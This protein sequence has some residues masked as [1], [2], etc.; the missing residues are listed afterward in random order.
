M[1]VIAWNCRSGT[2]EQRLKQV[3]R[4]TPDVLFLQECGADANCCRQVRGRKNIALMAPTGTLSTIAVPPTAGRGSIAARIAPSGSRP[5]VALGIWAQSPNYSADVI[6]TL[7]SYRLP[8]KSTI[9]LGDFNSG[10]RLPSGKVSTSHAAMLAAFERKGL[11]SA[12]HAF[13]DVDHGE[14]DDPTYFHLGK[15]ASPWHIDFCFVPR[16]WRERI[17]N[18]TVLSVSSWKPSSD[19]RPLL[20]DL[21]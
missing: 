11:I 17:R 21:E 1:R 7:D 8:W 4:Y 5:F 20:V 14:E 19:H 6:H 18:V 2:V 12:Y 15:R 3:E 16:E 10:T 13:H 9:V